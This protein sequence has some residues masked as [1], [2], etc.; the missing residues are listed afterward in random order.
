MEVC[1][2]PAK[3]AI[4]PHSLTSSQLDVAKSTSSLLQATSVLTQTIHKHHPTRLKAAIPRNHE[5][6]PIPSAAIKRSETATYKLLVDY[7][8]SSLNLPHQKHQSPIHT[9]FREVRQLPRLLRRHAEIE[10]SRNQRNRQDNTTICPYEPSSLL[11]K[12][13]KL[14]SAEFRCSRR[15]KC[16]LLWIRWCG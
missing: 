16:E 11:K 1:F 13:V 5:D 6:A 12:P 4:D 14:K 15:S 7:E 3:L 8:A 10:T 2:V 9:P